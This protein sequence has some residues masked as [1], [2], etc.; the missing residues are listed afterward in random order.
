MQREPVRGR[1]PTVVSDVSA[2]AN[3]L[4]RCQ[5]SQPQPLSLGQP[6]FQ[7]TRNLWAAHG[8]GPA[9]RG[10][11]GSAVA[12]PGGCSG[13]GHGRSRHVASRL[14]QR[15]SGHPCA[16]RRGAPNFVAENKF[17]TTAGRLV[18][19]SERGPKARVRRR[20]TVSKPIQSDEH[21]ATSR[22]RP[23]RS[24]APASV[25][26][27]YSGPTPTTRSRKWPRHGRARAYKRMQKGAV[28]VTAPSLSPSG[29]L[30]QAVVAAPLGAGLVFDSFRDPPVARISSAV[31]PPA[32][33][34]PR[35]SATSA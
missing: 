28:D 1:Q 22:C 27:R 23:S 30:S 19:P 24:G 12:Q 5:R 18:P 15:R 35:S 26:A 7:F 6:S 16:R 25:S 2:T 9:W 3:P 29:V 11:Q 4:S 10:T 33:N 20:W 8:I 34:R 14:A 31:P 13:R 21:L 17:V 32:I